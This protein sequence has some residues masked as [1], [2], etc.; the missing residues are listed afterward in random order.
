MCV[1]SWKIV[2]KQIELRDKNYNA[3]VEKNLMGL[4]AD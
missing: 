3:L 4:T 1:D 2:E